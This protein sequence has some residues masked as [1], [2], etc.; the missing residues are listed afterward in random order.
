MFREPPL[1]IP[2][3]FSHES[4]R[5]GSTSHR[6]ASG[7]PTDG[8]HD[9]TFQGVVPSSRSCWRY[10]WMFQEVTEWFVNGL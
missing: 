3:S 2:M 7:E 6:L 1:W 9:G 10:T 8:I 4:I 5:Q